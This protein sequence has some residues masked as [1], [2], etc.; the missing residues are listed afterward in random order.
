MTNSAAIGYMIIAARDAGLD[1]KTI[2]YIEMAM[3]TAMDEITEGEAEH[4]HQNN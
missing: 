3:Y 4:V 1:K 2:K